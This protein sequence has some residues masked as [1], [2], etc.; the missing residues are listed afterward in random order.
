MF[1]EIFSSFKHI[2]KVIQ[3]NEAED[4]IIENV[5]KRLQ[6]IFSAALKIL[7]ILL[8]QFRCNGMKQKVQS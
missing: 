5:S 3:W 7:F 4:K 2:P 8:E 1:L 6:K